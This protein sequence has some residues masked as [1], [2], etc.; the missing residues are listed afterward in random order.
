M[1]LHAFGKTT[2]LVVS[3]GEGVTHTVP[4]FEGQALEHS[5]SKMEIGGRNLTDYA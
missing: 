2:G 5:T 3:S 4:I 1:A